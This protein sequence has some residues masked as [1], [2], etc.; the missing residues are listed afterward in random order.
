MRPTL[1]VAQHVMTAL[2]ETRQPA[3]LKPFYIA[4]FTS[5]PSAPTAILA[6]DTPPPPPLRATP[7][8]YHYLLSAAIQLRDADVSKLWKEMKHSLRV[9]ALDITLHTSY[10]AL[11]GSDGRLDE[12]MKEYTILKRSAVRPTLLLL[13]T[14]L[15]SLSSEIIALSSP[16]SSSSTATIDS[17]AGRLGELMSSFQ[18]VLEDITLHSSRTGNVQHSVNGAHK[19][20]AGDQ[21]IVVRPAAS[22]PLLNPSLYALI[23]ATFS[24][25]RDTHRTLRYYQQYC[26]YCVS[27][28]SSSSS[29]S[30]TPSLASSSFSSTTH[31]A[32]LHSML[33]LYALQG[34]VGMMECY[35]SELVTDG[36]N[37]RETMET[38]LIGY[39]RADVL[40]RVTAV[41]SQ[42]H[43]MAA[44]APLK[45]HVRDELVRYH[46]RKG[47]TAA[48]EQL[49]HDGVIAADVEG[50]GN[51]LEAC[52]VPGESFESMWSYHSR[53]KAAHFLPS[54]GT[55]AQMLRAVHERGS[56]HDKQR[57]LA[58]LDE[59]AEGYVQLA[60]DAIVHTLVIAVQVGATDGKMHKQQL[61]RAKRKL[62]QA[63]SSVRTTH[64]HALLTALPVA[65]RLIA[66]E[67]ARDLLG[68]R[69]SD[70]CE[71]MMRTYQ[72]Q[73]A[74]GDISEAKLAWRW[75]DEWAV[76]LL[77]RV[78]PT[79]ALLRMH[80]DRHLTA[81][82]YKS[83][84][85]VYEQTM[86]VFDAL[87]APHTA[88]QV[89]K[90]HAAAMEALEDKATADYVTS[91]PASDVSLML[92]SAAVVLRSIKS[93]VT[94]DS[95]GSQHDKLKRIYSS[96][97]S[98][99]SQVRTL[100]VQHPQPTVASLEP[101]S[102]DSRFVR[103]HVQHEPQPSTADSN[104]HSTA[105]KKRRGTTSSPRGKRSRLRTPTHAYV[106]AG[107][108][109]APQPAV[110]V[111]VEHDAAMRYVVE[112][113]DAIRVSVEASD[114]AWQQLI[115]DVLHE[116][117]AIREVM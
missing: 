79:P 114:G 55:Y 96:L 73:L 92:Q 54:S 39:M 90:L 87:P 81:G 33:R 5:T 70:N 95:K 40:E 11:L 10:L 101:R 21:S 7:L 97:H 64:I 52:C 15:T 35:L 12:M 77:R 43:A 51:L 109:T 108:A 58:L 71:L 3:L 47:Q 65:E 117:H 34:D 27:V 2:T 50:Y 113:L 72:D 60:F 19:T 57:A 61:S 24:A 75:K 107:A 31:S 111:Y 32:I 82:D 26:Q 80:L 103:I 69:T 48:L 20:S 84:I 67:W 112:Q 56:L 94:T 76:M 29:S 88:E 4:H 53:M 62:N 9:S 99:L 13:S 74:T 37:D 6:A 115:D 86:R 23:I 42:W 89:A 44:S 78:L 17:S 45:Q 16:P 28:L 98:L 106:L 110:S 49:M 41:Y 46:V 68:K 93:E 83:F 36:L 30:S 102:M 105:R 1:T 59:I 85:T 8:C 18:H 22:G 104:Q 63:G 66:W 100:L 116:V 14:V 91:L 38:V 25:L